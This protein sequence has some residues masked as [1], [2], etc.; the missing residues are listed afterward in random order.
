MVVVV[1]VVVVV[2]VVVADGGASG[3]TPSLVRLVGMSK[4]VVHGIE[5]VEGSD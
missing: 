3:V 4:G 1:V 2:E 5:V